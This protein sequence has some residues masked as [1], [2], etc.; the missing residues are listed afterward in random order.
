MTRI[1]KTLNFLASTTVAG[2]DR[3][4]I[5]DMRNILQNL[6]ANEQCDGNMALKLGPKLE[7][8]LTEAYTTGV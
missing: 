1:Y 3:W 4:Y 8:V 7:E 5:V 2:R 6:L